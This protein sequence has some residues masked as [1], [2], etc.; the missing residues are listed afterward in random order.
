VHLSWSRK[1]ISAQVIFEGCVLSVK[2]ANCTSITKGSWSML[3]GEEIL[4]M[5]PDNRTKHVSTFWNTNA[6]FINMGL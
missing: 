3:F 2:K 6:A 1:Y 4:E 5:Y